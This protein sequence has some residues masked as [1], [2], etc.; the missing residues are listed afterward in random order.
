[1]NLRTRLLP[2]ARALGHKTAVQERQRLPSTAVLV[3]RYKLSSP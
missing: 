2:M 1:M 3:I